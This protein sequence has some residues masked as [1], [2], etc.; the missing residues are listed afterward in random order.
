MVRLQENGCAVLGIGR[1]LLDEHLEGW[2]FHVANPTAHGEKDD[3]THPPGG[4]RQG[5]STVRFDRSCRQE[6]HEDAPFR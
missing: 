6:P 2:R 3:R 4:W 5:R 1:R